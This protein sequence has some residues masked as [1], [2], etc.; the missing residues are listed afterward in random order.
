MKF[1][2]GGNIEYCTYMSRFFIALSN[3]IVRFK[4]NIV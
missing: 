3:Y 4:I 1:V 2:P